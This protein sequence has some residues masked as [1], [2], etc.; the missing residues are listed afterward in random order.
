MEEVTNEVETTGSTE[1][2]STDGA[3]G[4]SESSGVS[5]KETGS[6]TGDTGGETTAQKIEKAIEEA[7]K[8]TY[9]YKV[10]DKE[11]EFDDFVKPIIKDKTTEQ[12]LKELYEKA[13]GLDE[14]KSSRDNFKT[15]ANEWKTKYTN[16][17]QTLQTLGGYVKKGD[18]RSFFD[19]LKIPKDQ[20]IKYAIEELKF[21]ELPPEQKAEIERQRQIQFEYEQAQMQNQ[22]LQSQMAEIVQRQAEFELQ[23]ELAKPDVSQIVQSFNARMNNPNAFLAEVIRRGQYY[24]T[25]HKISPP[26]SQIVGEVIGLIGAGMTGQPA[27]TTTSQGSSSQTIPQAQKPVIPSLNGASNK[28]PVKKAVGSIEDLRK[29]RQQL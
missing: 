19:T 14:V 8:P 3:E 5:A 27:A 17:E 23:Q 13:Y 20:I 15:Q 9:K 26:A 10:N 25:V 6:T 11:L 22:T 21:Q 24:E 29:L 18:Y 16:V 28:S 2:V 4:V 12:K 7:Y 1:S